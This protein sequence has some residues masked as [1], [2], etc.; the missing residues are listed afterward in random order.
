MD[1]SAL[2][3]ANHRTC[4]RCAAAACIGVV[5]WRE[6]PAFIALT[7]MI[8]VLI[9]WEQSRV[10]AFLVGFAYYAAANWP[11]IPGVLSYFGPAGTIFQA[12]LF[13]A[14]PSLALP[15]PWVACWS[16]DASRGPWRLPLAYLLSVAPPIG[17]IGWA[18]PLTAAG[19]LF[20]GW[21]WIGLAL[22]IA[23]SALAL[24]RPV[25]AALTAA[26]LTLVA[27]IGY[28][29]DP[30]PPP[31]WD[32]VFTAFDRVSDPRDPMPE[33]Q[34]AERIQQR[35]L[36]SHREV[37]VFPESTVPKWT[38]ATELLW[39]RT[40]D[41]LRARRKTL[42]IGVGLPITGTPQCR[43]AVL[44][45][46]NRGA[47]LIL[48]RIPVPVIMWNPLKPKQGVPLR[49]FGPG[50]LEIEGQRVALLV[51]YEQLLTW[52]I[53]A[54]ALEHPTLIVGLANDNWAR[55]TPIA[56]AQQ[57]AVAAWARLLHLPKIMVVNL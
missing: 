16:A 10:D 15:L 27:N 52:P 13:W 3:R 14:I 5:A 53:L 57:A 38:E 50:I 42:V 49:L 45:V 26:L 54:S 41:E 6:T 34:V 24:Q 48:Q 37:I 23:V 21:A 55:G 20:P 44:V 28:P 2:I 35:A 51:C 1:I 36:A 46:G 9:F 19:I 7:A 8:P 43:N 56:A 39:G 30:S 29:G 32:G 17:I 25:E 31:S 18:S 33:F 4:A 40:L 22:F 47:S 12:F 11:L